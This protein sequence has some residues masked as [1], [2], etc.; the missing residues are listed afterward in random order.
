MNYKQIIKDI[1]KYRY[2][3]VVGRKA[4]ILGSDNESSYAKNE[5]LEKINLKNGKLE[6]QLVVRLKLTKVS[7]KLLESD[8]LSK[9]KTI[10]G[11]IQTNIDFYE[12]KDNNLHKLNEYSKNNKLFITDNF[13]KKMKLD[14][15]TIKTIASAA[16]NNKLEK[17]LFVL[18][19]IDKLIKL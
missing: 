18:N 6:N 12:I 16:H 5:A 3:L 15:H 1:G 4:G 13:L 10:G 14:N 2:V 7:S 8:N 11:P 19:K 17:E 9:I